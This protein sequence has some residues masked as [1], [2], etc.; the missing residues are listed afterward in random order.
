VSFIAAG[1]CTIDASQDGDATYQAAPEVQQSFVVGKGSQTITFT[2][3]PPGSA[4]PG[5]PTYAARA[6]ASSGLPVTFSSATPSVCSLEGATVSF[7]AA[8]TCTVRAN[9]TGNSNYDPAPEVQ[10][11]F[12]VAK[13]SQ[14]ISFTS[15]IPGSATAG[16]PSYELTAT[17]SSGLPVS[18]SSATPSVCTVEGS[19]VSFLQAGTCTIDANQPGDSNYN[20]APEAQQSFAV[21]SPPALMATPTPSPPPAASAP[22][23]LAPPFTPTAPDSDFSL[24]R[25]P[26][27][28]TKTGAITFTASVSNPGIFAWLLTFP[29][30]TFGAF[31]AS[32]SE[33]GARQIR[34]KGKCRPAQIVFAKSAVS[35][36]GA[37]ATA[38]TVTF[39]ATPSSSA[40]KALAKAVARGVGL[41]VTAVLGFRSSLGGSS[42]SHTYTITAR[43]A[44]TSR[45]ARH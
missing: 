35:V 26:I 36:A 20:P 10:Q 3:S 16:G 28:N 5:G 29:N 11:S 32:R 41:P 9:Q 43:L 6:T 12:A 45:G 34:V 38:V 24:Q 14:L 44:Q 21:A 40:R 1:T 37:A 33:C 22:L 23:P 27:V 31:S 42:V 17:A 30:G 18:L 19:T 2:S 7:V 13:G 8:G 39:K 4:S 25:N 15:D